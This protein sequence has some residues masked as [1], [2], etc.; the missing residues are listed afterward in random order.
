[1]NESDVKKQIHQMVNFIKQEA[2]EKANEIMVK[3]EEEFNIEKLRMVEAEKQKIRKD[4]ERKEKQVEVQKK[5]AYSMEVN[6]SRLRCLKTRDEALQ[7]IVSDVTKILADI[8]KPSDKYKQ[9][10]KELI[11]QGLVMLSEKQA[12]I[13]CREVDLFFMNEAIAQATSEYKKKTGNDVKITVDSS[14]FLP[15]PPSPANAGASC[16]GG[17]ILT[18][19]NGKISLNNTLDARLDIAYQSQL[20]KIRK[21]LFGAAKGA[22]MVKA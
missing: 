1:M 20:P 22:S 11:F 13:R 21:T 19:A 7:E 17:I 16:A 18:T 8:G 12:I 6:A 10:V 14:K 9:L 4:Y 15:P 3:A 2:Q 5:I